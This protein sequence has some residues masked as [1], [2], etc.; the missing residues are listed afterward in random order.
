VA[1][2]EEN[3]LINPDVAYERAD[4]KLTVFAML[5]IGL[6]AYLVIV[7]LVLRAGYPS[8]ARDVDRELGARAPAPELQI[9]PQADLRAFRAAEEA[10]LNS[11]G[12]VERSQ[13]IVHIPIAQAMR[14]VAA[15]G[16]PDFPRAAP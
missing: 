7:P 8:A 16:I 9:D 15:K 13:G 1:E 3:F 10:R 6:I 11:Y 5:A 12:W 2:R 4:M 14:Q